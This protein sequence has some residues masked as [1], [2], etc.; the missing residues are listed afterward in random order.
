MATSCPVSPAACCR[1]IR[2]P[3]TRRSIGLSFHLALP[4]NP[5]YSAGTQSKPEPESEVRKLRYSI[6]GQRWSIDFIASA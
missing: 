3:L 4:F 6:S 1:L 2:K 5:A